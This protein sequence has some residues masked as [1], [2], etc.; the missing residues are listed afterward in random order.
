LQ[1]QNAAGN[2]NVGR[3]KYIFRATIT[4]TDT[5]NIVTEALSR[6]GRTLGNWDNR[7]EFSMFT[8]EG[9]AILGTPNG[10]GVA[11]FLINH[12]AQM[13]VKTIG[14]VFVWAE[15]PSQIGDRLERSLLF[16]IVDPL[17]SDE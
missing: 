10:S 1:W 9:L 14:S 15:D 4:N 6:T 16:T 3:L 17:P 8:K 13:G 7:V 2:A 12:K 11:W 5:Q